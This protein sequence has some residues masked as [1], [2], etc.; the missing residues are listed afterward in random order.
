MPVIG[1]L[2][3]TKPNSFNFHQTGI[4]FHIWGYRGWI[5]CLDKNNILKT[6]TNEK[7]SEKF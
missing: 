4:V 1:K 7:A 6:L 2:F 3:L 5:V